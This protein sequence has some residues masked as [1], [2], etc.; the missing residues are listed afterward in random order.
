MKQHLEIQ[1]MS[2]KHCQMRTEKA[3]NQVKGV[4]NVK[5]D[6]MNNEAFVETDGTVTFEMMKNAVE[7]AGYEL[8]KAEEV[9]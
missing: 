4:S 9:K 2:C 8:T 5:V 3:L 1:G 7:D 6:F